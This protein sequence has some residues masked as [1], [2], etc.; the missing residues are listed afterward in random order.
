MVY[1]EAPYTRIVNVGW[2]G[3]IVIAEFKDEFNVRFESLDPVYVPGDIGAGRYAVGAEIPKDDYE[4]HIFFAALDLSGFEHYVAEEELV[5]PYTTPFKQGFRTDAENRDWLSFRDGGAG[6]WTGFW[7]IDENGIDEITEGSEAE[8]NKTVTALNGAFADILNL[9]EFRI[10]SAG[11]IWDVESWVIAKIV[12]INTITRLI[13]MR[14]TRR[15][16]FRQAAFSTDPDPYE[17]NLLVRLRAYSGGTFTIGADKRLSN[18]GGKLL[19][20]QE[21][22]TPFRNEEAFDIVEFTKSGVIL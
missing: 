13:N 16:K 18:S 22:T 7:S 5:V 8:A 2:Q 4:D 21:I 1:R 19:W 15:V 17:Y 9:I 12:E 10:S 14:N 11:V 6:A 3:G 20:E